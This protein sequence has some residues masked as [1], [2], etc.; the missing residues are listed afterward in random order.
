VK[1][2][3]VNLTDIKAI[4]ISNTIPVDKELLLLP[5][6]YW[7]IKYCQRVS[8]IVTGTDNSLTIDLDS[9]IKKGYIWHH[10]QY[11]D[12]EHSVNLEADYNLCSNYILKTFKKT[13]QA[14]PKIAI[15]QAPIAPVQITP[16]IKDEYYELIEKEVNAINAINAIKSHEYAINTKI[17]K[18]LKDIVLPSITNNKSQVISK[19]KDWIINIWNIFINEIDNIKTQAEAFKRN[20]CLIELDKQLTFLEELKMEKDIIKK[21]HEYEAGTSSFFTIKTKLKTIINEIINKIK[22]NQMNTSPIKSWMDT[23]PIISCMN[24]NLQKAGCINKKLIKKGG[25]KCKITKLSQLNMDTQ[26]GKD[27]SKTTEINVNEQTSEDQK[28]QTLLDHFYKNPKEKN[29]CLVDI[30]KKIY[31]EYYLMEIPSPPP[32]WVLQ[33]LAYNKKA[34]EPNIKEPTDYSKYLASLYPNT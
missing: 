27:V 18:A 6:L 17:S 1:K 26:Y 30:A 15:V 21:L 13:V 19:F 22:E 2:I 12:I 25:Y 11:L 23:S 3:T 24:L 32:R 28:L 20:T 33:V 5:G 31:M 16:I 14:A 29:E 8:D 4:L 7:F 9:L 10:F 34:E